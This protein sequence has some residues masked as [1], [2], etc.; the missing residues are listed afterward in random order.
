MFIKK[1]SKDLFLVL[2][3]FSKITFAEIAKNYLMENVI[4]DKIIKI[5]GFKNYYSSNFEFVS[6]VKD[7]NIFKVL[8]QINIQNNNKEKLKLSNFIQTIFDCKDFTFSLKKEFDLDLHN[9][10]YEID[11]NNNVTIYPKNHQNR[12]YLQNNFHPDNQ[13]KQNNNFVNYNQQKYL[14]T[15]FNQ[16]K[17][18]KFY[19]GN[20]NNSQ[21]FISNKNIANNSNNIFNERI[22]YEDIEE[23]VEEMENLE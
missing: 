2:M 4:L 23:D 20:N 1:N 16:N 8:F 11:E 19:K 14:Q 18:R 21:N 5:F 17:K 9:L 7:N 15:D 10:K 13:H 3:N 6:F 22:Y 12:N